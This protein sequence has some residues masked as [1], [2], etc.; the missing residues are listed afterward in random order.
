[1]LV[2]DAGRADP[3][4]TYPDE[5]LYDAIRTMLTRDVGRLPVVERSDPTRIVG[6]LGRA[7]ILGARLRLH[8]EEERRE[9]GPSLFAPRV[10][11]TPA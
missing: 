6:Y 1:M 8:D 4:L 3:P 7:E 2:R 5:P 11:E 9:R 10:P